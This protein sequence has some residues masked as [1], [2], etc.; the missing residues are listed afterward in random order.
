MQKNKNVGVGSGNF[1]L[2]FATAISCGLQNFIENYQA[3]IDL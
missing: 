3:T 1:A 2:L